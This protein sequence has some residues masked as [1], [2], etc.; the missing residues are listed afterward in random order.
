MAG[1]QK[2]LAVLY[3]FTC[4]TPSVMAQCGYQA[5]ITTNHNYCV[6]SA[7]IA[8]STHALQQIVWYHNGQ[9]VNTVTGTQSLDT[10]PLVVDLGKDS[11]ASG[12]LRLCA[13][14]AGNIYAFNGAEVEILSPPG[15]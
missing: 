11:F 7:L 10:V 6:G 14:G 1:L 9:P 13:D 3:C 12:I 2:Y 5:T 15:T 8:K 4:L